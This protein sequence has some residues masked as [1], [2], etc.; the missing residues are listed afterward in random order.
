LFIRTT[1]TFVPHVTTFHRANLH[2]QQYIIAWSTVKANVVNQ[3]HGR[4]SE[5]KF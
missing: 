1:F 4:N 5:W 3:C 2:Q